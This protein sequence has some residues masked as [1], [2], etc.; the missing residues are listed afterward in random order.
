MLLD[1]AGAI[2]GRYRKTHLPLVEAEAGVTPGS[3]Y[4]V[5]KT[6]FGM[7]GLLVCWDQ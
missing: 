7:I 5:F 1:R 3:A 4:P 2:A 6:D